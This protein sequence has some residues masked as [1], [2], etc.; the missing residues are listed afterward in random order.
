MSLLAF[1]EFIQK[2]CFEDPDKF[3]NLFI[4]ELR[5]E[6]KDVY[7]SQK[8]QNPKMDYIAV[9]FNQYIRDEIQR[10]EN[11]ELFKKIELERMQK[12]EQKK[13]QKAL[14][15]YPKN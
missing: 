13:D 4:E 2:F 6:V 5:E 15:H 10:D 3:V 1:I 14:I 8:L 12:E 11:P 9:S 7:R